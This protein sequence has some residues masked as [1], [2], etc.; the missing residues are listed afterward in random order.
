MPNYRPPFPA[1]KGLYG[2]PTLV[3]NAETYSLVPWI[4]RNGAEAFAALGTAQSKGTKVFSLA[5]KIERGGLIEVPMGIT[6]NEVVEKIGGGISG[7]RVFKAVQIGGP[8]GGCIPASLGDTPVDFE[9]LKDVGAMMGS[10]GFVVLDDSDCMVE[11]AHYFLSFTQSESCGKCTPCRVG[12]KRM[13]EVLTRLCNG[14]GRPG[15]IEKLEQLARA[16]KEQSLCGLGKTAPNPILTTIQYFRD[17]FEEHI[18]GRCP[19]GKCQKM[20]SYSI[21]DDC[22]GCTKCAVECP[23]GAI[24]GEPYSVFEIDSERC[25]RCDNCRQVCPVDAVIVE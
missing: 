21:N 13:L 25:I 24:A 22:I 23:V 19:A 1:E 10:G 12:T 8:S 3:N 20:I 17:E 7:G 15:D 6:I 14:Q 18:Q 4:I 16:V 2:G 9:A 5:G 11:M